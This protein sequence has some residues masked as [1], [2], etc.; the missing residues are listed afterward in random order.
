M[1]ESCWPSNKKG[2]TAQAT[3]KALCQRDWT[4]FR[5]LSVIKSDPGT[6]FAGQW[7]NTLCAQL[8]VWQ[9]FSQAHYPPANGR[10]EVA[11]PHLL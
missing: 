2:L 11:G 1:D 8:G 7:F 4:K 9:A 5:M 6:N 3:A 10:A